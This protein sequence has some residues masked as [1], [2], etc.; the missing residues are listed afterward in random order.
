MVAEESPSPIPYREMGLTEKVRKVLFTPS[1]F[2]ERI[3]AEEDIG[4]A[5][6][7]LAV[8]LFL[9]LTI[10]FIT[11]QFNLTDITLSY[12]IVFYIGVLIL[13]FISIGIIHLFTKL[14][15]GR[16]NFSS[17]YKAFIYGSTP[18]L[19]LGLI[20]WININFI[21]WANIIVSLYS[22][23]LAI[24]GISKLHE[25][26]MLRAFVIVFILPLLITMII[27]MIYFI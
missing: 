27:G 3:R 11:Y 4:E 17:T 7:Y 21:R 18:L 14:L 25:V 8:F 10:S 13:Q 22:L 2:F 19:L 6:K 24:K 23:Y 15:K 26:S 16:G 9:Q 12:L 1:E 20:F 5:F